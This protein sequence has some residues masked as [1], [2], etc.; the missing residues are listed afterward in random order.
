MKRTLSTSSFKSSAQRVTALHLAAV[1]AT[2]V[3]IAAGIYLHSLIVRREDVTC[4]KTAFFRDRNY[5]VLFF[6]TSHVY[7]S[8]SPFQLY[9]DYGITSYNFACSSLAI[10]WSYY[11][12]QNALRFHKPK[13]AVLDVF[14]CYRNDYVVVNGHRLFDNF[15]LSQEKVH[16]ILQL[17]DDAKSQTELLFPY[18]TN[19]NM[20]NSV[21]ENFM[22]L[23]NSNF[24]RTNVTNG[25]FPGL[26]VERN[27]S[28]YNRVKRLTG[29]E[30]L[31]DENSVGIQYIKKFIS[32]CNNNG[33]Q[34]V[35]VYLP[36]VSGSRMQQESNTIQKLAKLVDVPY[37]NMLVNDRQIVDCYTDF[38]D[39]LIEPEH[40]HP[41]G[42]IHMNLS[43]ARKVTDYIG[44]I[45]RT[46]FNVADHRG[47]AGY[48]QW[49]DDYKVY[50]QC[51][52]DKISNLDD[53]D[54]LLMA[55][56]FDGISVTLSVRQGTPLDFVQQRLIAQLKD[57]ISVAYFDDNE[58]DYDV[59]VTVTDDESG[60]TVTEKD[61]TVGSALH[62]L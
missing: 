25:Y 31:S 61:F 59:R 38:Y 24:T 44:S 51:V 21:P 26:H 36:P 22:H 40:N 60:S 49:E 17:Y 47:E 55:C 42:N 52:L 2:L 54:A 4:D 32:F 16:S 46:D 50:R 23:W 13:V 6:G 43:G 53:F 48:E 29:S 56:N 8:I 27:I 12:L 9:K 57:S 37:Y 45:L 34:P 35:L 5:D 58:H 1:L 3:L 10:S 18:T 7:C 15:T 11:G 20:W 14:N 33:I 28:G 19:H 41:L 30:Y 39:I 62:A